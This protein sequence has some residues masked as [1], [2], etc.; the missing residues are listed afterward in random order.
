MTVRLDVGDGR[1]QISAHDRPVGTYITR[2]AASP[3]EVPKPYL[4][5]IRTLTGVLVTDYA[6]DD[7]RWHHG[8]MMGMPRVGGHNLWGG[9][10]FVDCDQGYVM[11]P[12][13]GSIRHESW[14]P[15]IDD[16][17]AAHA[18][19]DL[20]WLGHKGELLLRER[21]TIEVADVLNGWGLHHV[22]ELTNATAEPIELASPAQR[23]APD[24]GYGGLFLRLAAGMQ[25]VA[26]YTEMKPVTQSGSSSPWL[27]VH[28]TT[29][30]GHSLTLGLGHDEDWPVAD[31][32]WVLRS[33][34]FPA[35][36]W[37]VVY[38]DVISLEPRASVRMGHRLIVLDGTVEAATVAAA[39]PAVAPVRCGR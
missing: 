17:P 31:P 10:T 37:G 9:P 15:R 22:S 1:V 5:P 18:G 30:D 13:Q 36:G 11:L 28:A 23:G 38:D 24:K 39:L 26:I 29:S 2:S 35:I 6:P 20:S 4:H 12:D 16:D 27:V 19:E 7:H 14:I 33:E 32:R 34:K 8:L 3:V 21:R 25:V